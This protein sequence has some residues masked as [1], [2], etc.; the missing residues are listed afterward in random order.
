[1]CMLVGLVAST[2]VPFLLIFMSVQA[3]PS[4]LNIA[5]N[6][7]AQSWKC[8]GYSCAMPATSLHY[9]KLICDA[10]SYFKETF[11]FVLQ[12]K[13]AMVVCHVELPMCHAPVRS[14]CI[15]QAYSSK[16]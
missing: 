6:L 5:W 8:C 1:M 11:E 3:W 9:T 2:K 16:I 12:L 14:N 15:Y 10:D 13:L 7:D 4:R